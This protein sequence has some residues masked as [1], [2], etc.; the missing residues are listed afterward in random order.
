[1]PTKI[2]ILL[3]ALV[4]AAALVAPQFSAPL[5]QAAC[6]T[7]YVAP[8]GSDTNSGCTTSTPWK[9]ITQVNATTFTAGNQILFQR[10]GTWTGQLQPKG[11]GTNGSPVI[12]S[13]YGSGAQP[14]IAG[15]GAAAAFSLSDQHDWTV[16]NLELTNKASGQAKRAGFLAQNTTSGTLHGIHVVNNTIDNISGYFANGD[17]QPTTTSAISLNQ[18]DSNTTAAWDDVLID[19]NT[20]SKVDAGGIYIGSP[21]G[22]NHDI[23]STNIVIQNNTITDAGGN[24]IVC[25]FCKA[26][27]V[28]YNVDTDSGYRYSGAALW[29]GWTT[30][31]VWQYNEVARN[32]RALYDGQAF[33]IDNN[34]SDMVLQ[35]N[36]THDNPWGSME[37]CCSASFGSLGTSVIRYNIS[38]N[39]GASNAVWGT[40]QGIQTGA[41]A[42]FYNNTVYMGPGDNGDVTNGAAPSGPSISFTNNLIYKLGTGGYATNN[43]TWS[44]NLFYG[45]HP[46]TEPSDSAKVTADP[47]LVNPGAAGDGRGSASVY[48]LLS[49]SPALGAGTVVSGN[50]GKDYFGNTVSSTAA[51]NIGAYNGAAV[52][53]TAPSAGAYWRFDEGTGTRA[54][55][56]A[57]H[58]NTG[59][60]QA[61]ASW[62]TDAQ[63]GTAAVSLNGS[64][65]GYVDVANA[66]VDTSKS[67]TVATWVKPTSI[68]GNQTYLSI[69]GTTVSPFY[70]QIEK[71][72]YVFTV[73]AS[74]SNT[75][76]ATQVYGSAATVG[77]WTQLLGVY[78]ATAG[79]IK[80]YV[81]GVLQGSAPFTSGWKAAGHTKIGQAKY[82]GAAVDF[83]NAIIDDVHAVQSAVSDREAFALG[84]GA[85]A[86]YELDE[87]SGATFADATGG[88]PTGHLE[89]GTTWTG[90]GK[91]G[92]NS[93]TFPG[94]AGAYGTVPV[95]AIDTSKSYSVS[96]WVNLASTAGTQTFA[97]MSG[98][99]ISPFYLQ[100]S[101]GKFHFTV[102]DSDSKNSKATT[103]DGSATVATGT[104]YHV[105]GTYDRSAGTIA[106]YVNG[107][108]QGTAAYTTPWKSIG[109]TTIGGAEFNLSPVDPVNGRVDD[110]H[111]YNRTLTAA[112]ISTLAG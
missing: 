83:A 33:D 29:S 77:T 63:M 9:S 38:Q 99:N 8:S 100:M 67:Y 85:T 37:F 101:G 47:M 51:P 66:A 12:V 2:R 75:A 57:Q 25:V 34:N 109:A 19:G 45:D 23:N 92:S 81:N 27:L 11:S 87:G 20:L 106:L 86:Y 39:D 17:S 110:V 79:T 30:N 55:D 65:N 108:S 5:A 71:G 78:D 70:L 88:T 50:G 58:L 93:L 49:G 16:Q 36:Y 82:N 54:V 105:L 80:L 62:S 84:T 32:W 24:S 43:T 91:V 26:P 68:A 90:T 31:G 103:V 4:A 53:P 18:T 96:A 1:M 107:V 7:Y 104:W 64:A 15:A 56:S 41:K 35:Y 10:G 111:F 76:A 3:A 48:R 59:T 95:S 60:L 73:R 97:T 22:L 40:Q 13:A 74:D 72:K 28:Q 46:S 98:F 21:I 112:Q 69:D 14:I 6:S 52:A 42:Q 61:G 44:H 94:A 102:R 89:S